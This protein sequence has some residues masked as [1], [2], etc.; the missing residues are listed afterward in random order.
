MFKSKTL[1][2]LHMLLEKQAKETF[3]K[4]FEIGLER[5][6]LEAFSDHKLIDAIFKNKYI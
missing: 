2:L 4:F 5:I 3:A 6:L 1:M